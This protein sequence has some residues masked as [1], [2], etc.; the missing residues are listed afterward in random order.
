ME[1]NLETWSKERLIAR[2][3][4]LEAMVDSLK[5]AGSDNKVLSVKMRFN[6]T[7]KQARLLTVL[8]DGRP[9]TKRAIYEF[10]YHDE[11]DDPPEMRVIDVFMVHVRKKIAPFGLFI[12]TMRGAGDSS[13]FKLNDATLF[14]LVMSDEVDLETLPK[15]PQRERPGKEN[16]NLVMNV[17]CQ[18]M[19]SSGRAKMLGRSIAKAA[20]LTVTVGSVMKRLEKKKMVKII[21]CPRS[22]ASDRPWIVQVRAQK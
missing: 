2:I 1:A 7:F 16:E 8:S 19:D 3:N 20:G 21:G 10:V 11:F 5:T 4:D 12:T 6:L 17:L 13:G 22:G 15:A 18:A 9:K 14:D